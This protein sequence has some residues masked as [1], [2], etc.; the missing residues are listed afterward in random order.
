VED[1]ISDLLKIIVAFIDKRYKLVEEYLSKFTD[2]ILLKNKDANFN[3]KIYLLKARLAVV[4][5]NKRLARRYYE[6]IQSP[7]LHTEFKKF[8]KN[9]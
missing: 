6:E 5:D 1:D 3:D 9:Y 7:I 8:M 2:D 4:N